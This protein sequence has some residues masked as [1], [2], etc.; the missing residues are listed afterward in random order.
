MGTMDEFRAVVALL[1]SGALKPVVDEVFAPEDAQRAYGRLE[2]G[3][4]FGKLVFRWN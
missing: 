1:R 3:E 4:Q 2:A